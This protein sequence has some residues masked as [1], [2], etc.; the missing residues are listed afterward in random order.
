MVLDTTTSSLWAEC[1][2]YAFGS[3]VLK[4]EGLFPLTHHRHSALTPCPIR[5]TM[6]EPIILL[7]LFP[8]G[9]QEEGC[10]FPQ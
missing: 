1:D 9:E 6:L 3:L 7:G 10:Y 8:P 4:V 5:G 2:F